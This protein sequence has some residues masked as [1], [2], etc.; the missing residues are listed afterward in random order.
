M[1]ASPSS[2]RQVV[3]FGAYEADLRSG[4]LRMNGVRV[5]LPEQPFQLLA[6]LLKHPGE[7]VTR[8]EL[9]EHLWPDGTFV[10]FEQGL[11]AVVKRLRE[12][13]E[14]PAETPGLIETVPAAATA[15]SVLWNPVR[16]ASS[17]WRFCPWRISPAIPSRITSQTD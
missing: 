9:Q 14:D 8:K 10:D 13:L 1:P 17:R 11:N 6:I 5:R 4:E 7:I 3:R 16:G 2:G 12:A 15:S